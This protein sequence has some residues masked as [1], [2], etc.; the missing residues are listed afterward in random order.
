MS[1]WG[2]HKGYHLEWNDWKLNFFLHNWK[3]M[4]VEVLRQDGAPPFYSNFEMFWGT[5]SRPSRSSDSLLWG[6]LMCSYAAIEP[7]DDVETFGSCWKVPPEMFQ[8]VCAENRMGLS[9]Q[10][11]MHCRRCT[12][13]TSGQH[14]MRVPYLVTWH[15]FENITLKRR[16]TYFVL[17]YGQMRGRALCA[18]FNYARWLIHEERVSI[19]SSFVCVM[20]AWHCPDQ[21]DL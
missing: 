12:Y 15:D 19:S 13:G 17:W 10:C 20:L 5:S 18:G 9:S 7:A 14:K 8:N 6:A 4:K 16:R 21:H 11:L 1:F 3:N 2:D